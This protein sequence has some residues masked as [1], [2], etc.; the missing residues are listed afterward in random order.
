MIMAITASTLIFQPPIR[1]QVR[2]ISAVNNVPP[3]L[4]VGD[5]TPAFRTG[6]IPA[7]GRTRPL[8]LREVRT[9][10]HSIHTLQALAH[11]VRLGAARRDTK[12]CMRT[13]KFMKRCAVQVDASSKALATVLCCFVMF[14]VRVRCRD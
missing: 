13:D 1:L 9:R 10:C 6:E 7:P 12:Q 4:E 14:V 11:V 3:Q 8:S 5:A 2:D